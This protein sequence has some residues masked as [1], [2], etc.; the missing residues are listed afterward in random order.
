MR[1]LLDFS[2]PSQDQ[3]RPTDLNDLIS[4]V[5]TIIRHLLRMNN[6]TLRLELWD[7]LPMVSVDPN[8]IQQVLHNLM[9]NAI[10]AMPSGGTLTVGTALTQKPNSGLAP[11][12]NRWVSIVVQDTGIGIPPENLERIFEPFFTHH[13][14]SRPED[15]GI[16]LG[17]SVS[18]GIIK[19]HGGSIEV[20]STVNQGSRF[21]VYLPLEANPQT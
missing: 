18:Y 13:T 11:D 3:R 20:D 4:Q 17:L 7:D 12:E 1:G 8:Q 16:G 21:A 9:R 6:L 14:S 19:S 10:Q 15:I 5:L 2:R